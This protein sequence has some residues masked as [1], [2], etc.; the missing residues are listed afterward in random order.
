MKILIS[1]STGLIGTGLVAALKER[2]DDV[3]RLL[4][5]DRPTEGGQHANTQRKY[6][7]TKSTVL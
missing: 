5:S 4:R 3:H 6:D 1:G 7:G 2:G